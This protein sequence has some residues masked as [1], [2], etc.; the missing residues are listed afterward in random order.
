M[1]N[2]LRIIEDDLSGEAIA[3]L[4]RFHFDEMHQW[5]PPDSCHVMTVERLRS[6]DV[7]F[8]SAWA[9]DELAGCGALKRI[10][11]GHGELKS[12]R[13]APAWRGKGVGRAMLLH[14]IAEAR[15]RGYRRLS[16]ETGSSAPFAAAQGLYAA[17]GFT[18]CGPFADYR[19]DPFSVFMTRE[20]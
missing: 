15:A 9:G 7:T 6:P 5:S 3:A 2:G 17:H 8:Y 16:L 10:D 19:L 14:L 11:D 1:G 12:M 20:L 18:V 4:I 13:A